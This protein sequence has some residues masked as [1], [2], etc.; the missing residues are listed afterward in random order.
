M[1]RDDVVI[2]FYWIY[3]AQ[4]QYSDSESDW[5]E[6]DLEVPELRQRGD[7]DAAAAECGRRR[8]ARHT[9]RGLGPARA[10]G[11]RSAALRVRLAV[12]HRGTGRAGPPGGSCGNCDKAFDGTEFAGCPARRAVAHFATAPAGSQPD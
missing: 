8:G 3:I 2:V 9:S 10:Q 5:K 4:S 6:L 7:A 12:A 11:L 1:G